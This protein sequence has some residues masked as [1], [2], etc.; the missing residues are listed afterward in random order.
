MSWASVFKFPP[1]FDNVIYGK[2]MTDFEDKEVGWKE[3]L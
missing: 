1:S 3:W 2:Q